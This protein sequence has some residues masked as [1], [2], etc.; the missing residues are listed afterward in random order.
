MGEKWTDLKNLC[1]IKSSILDGGLEVNEGWEEE[2]SSVNIRILASYNC[3]D[4]S[5]FKGKK[6]APLKY[7]SL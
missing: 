4:T 7:H 2:V 1:E 3:I 6:P 5:I